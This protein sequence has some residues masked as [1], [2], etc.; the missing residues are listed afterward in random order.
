VPDAPS[1]LGITGVHA[2]IF[3]PEAKRVRAFLRDVLELPYVD[4]HDGWLIFALPP[5]EVAAHPASDVDRHELFLMCEDIHATVA[6][7]E[8]RGVEL[9]G[10]VIEED[11][12][13]LTA[14]RMPDGGR[15]QLYQPT[16]PSPI[17]HDVDPGDRFLS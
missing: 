11:F 8:R 1:K 7:L 13:L 5:A 3:T 12:G 15:L 4:A 14:I 9:T 6:E 2:I 17:R 16:H 10:P